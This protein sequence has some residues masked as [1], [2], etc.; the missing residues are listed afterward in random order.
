VSEPDT[1]LYDAMNKGAALPEAT[2]FNHLNAGDRLVDL[3]V[4]EL[5]IARKQNLDV[6]TFRCWSTTIAHSSPP[7]GR[8][9]AI[10]RTRCIIKAP[11]IAGRRC[12]ATI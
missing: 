6:A 7:A 9:L 5:E 11:F 3:P 4:C 12:R 10:Q 1:G 2:L 8:L